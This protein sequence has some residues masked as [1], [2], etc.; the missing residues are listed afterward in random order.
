MRTIIKGRAILL[1]DTGYKDDILVE[2]ASTAPFIF[3]ENTNYNSVSKIPNS[4]LA[5]ERLRTANV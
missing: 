2:S 3:F 1:E 5:N 4:I